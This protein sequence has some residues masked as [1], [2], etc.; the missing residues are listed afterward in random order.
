MCKPVAMLLIALCLVGCSSGRQKMAE[1]T[2]RGNRIVRALEQYHADRGR[3]P[4]SLTDLSPKYLREIPPPTWGLRTWQYQSRAS[5]FTLRVDESVHTGDG[6][7]RWL[8]YMG[9]QLGWQVGD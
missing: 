4:N 3:Y 8:Q 9:K 6:D 2:Q 7:S 5:D 1:T